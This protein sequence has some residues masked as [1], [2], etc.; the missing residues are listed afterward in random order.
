MSV[1]EIR[2]PFL[3]ILA[4]D[5]NPLKKQP[6]FKNPTKDPDFS[7]VTID[8]EKGKKERDK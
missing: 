8:R 6:E 7:Q 5:T 2:S 4:L 3:R 1:L